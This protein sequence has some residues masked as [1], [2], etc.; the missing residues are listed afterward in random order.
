VG[1]ATSSL[2]HRLPFTGRLARAS[3][4]HPWRVLGLWVV[5][6][7]VAY[8]A[9]GTMNLTAASGS[10]GT[11]ATKA[12]DLIDQRLR[13]DTP[14]E[15]FIVVESPQMTADEAGYG[16]FVEAL[17]G[18]L[19]GLKEV[20]TV[21]SYRDG[22]QGLVS[23]DGHTVLIPVT[24]IGDKV[25]AADN[26]TSLIDAV[27]EAD[28][29]DAFRVTTVGFGSVENEM[30]SSLEK[31]LQQ[32]EMIGI[33]VALVILVVVFG[34]VVAAGLPIALALLSIF[35]AVGATALVSNTME[36]S[37]FVVFIITM[38]GLAVGIDY[39]LFIVQRFREERVLGMDKI[40]AI[41]TAGATASRTVMFSG[42]AVAIALAG[43]LIMPDA[44]FRSFAVGAILV[45]GATVLAAMTLLPAVLGL[46][47]DRV[48]WLTLPFIGR[49]G[50]TDGGGVWSWVAHAVMARPVI[51]VVVTGGLLVAA[52]APV[53]DINLGSVGISSLPDD[54]NSR[55]AF[56]VINRDFSD[57]VLTADVVIDTRDVED[58][59]VQAAIAELNAAI[60]AD[61]FF[62][63]AKLETNEAGDLALLTVAMPGDFSSSESRAALE[64][65]RGDYIPAAFD[66]VPAEVS[67][68][69][70]TAE[71]VD[72]VQLQ[73]DYL[74]LVF[75][76]VLGLSFLLLVVVFRSIVVPLKAVLLNL[77]SAGAA[78][79]ILVL[80]FQHGIGASLLGFREAPVIESWLPL[81]LFAILFGLSMDYHVFLLSRIKEHY[82]ETRDNAASVAHGLRST[83]GIITGAAL[84]MVAVFAGMA[85]GELVT[86]QQ[87]GFGLAVAVIL[88]AT[89]IRMVLVPA[90]MELLGDWNWYFPKWLMWLPKVNIEGAVAPAGTV[91]AEADDEAAATTAAAMPVTA[92]A[93]AVRPAVETPALA[94]TPEAAPARKGSPIRS[95]FGW[96]GII[97]I[98]VVAVAAIVGGTT[99]ALAVNGGPAACEAGGA[100]IVVDDAN[101]EAFDAKWDAF[102]FALASGSHASVT[103]S[104][105]EVTSRLNA[106]NDGKDIFDEIRVCLHD[107]YGE[108][109]GTLDG[110]GPVDASFK[111]TGT[112]DL[113]GEH[114]EARIRDIDLGKVPG[115]VLALWEGEAEDPIN[116]ALDQVELGHT[117]TVA[118]FEGGVRIDGQP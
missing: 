69:G 104:E 100:P 74:P 88:D 68:G 21:S 99:V 64:R 31:T 109:T 2:R 48:N 3:A 53:F 92:A 87:V 59:A 27:D 12:S 11:E 54:S 72:S 47:G 95:F 18:D 67:V 73:R 89:I 103:F 112:V 38:I 93:A 114:P 105:S 116:D 98:A 51:S 1:G 33:V 17:V 66:G 78:Y 4:R 82:D 96:L 20:S 24:L 90:S 75:T 86:F 22:D 8:F 111:L 61:G 34:A 35:V 62:G 57:G 81:F 16:D 19:R 101:A 97:L 55:H 32:G 10:A 113:G 56:A 77:L 63:N 108:A 102:Q 43:M 49:R 39:S 15:E 84:I 30:T 44:T 40:D 115:A 25:D 71:T 42:M 28:G 94:A 60:E 85:S 5:L 52:A 110:G 91:N 7:A 14:P 23:E 13:H 37:N 118:Y 6:V 29:N 46:M 26:S 83:A 58:P 50:R 36:T 65:L 9:A 45:V 79:G 117:Y 80:V 107:G 76:F 70:A 41:A 106:W